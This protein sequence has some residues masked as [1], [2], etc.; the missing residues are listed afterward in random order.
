[1]PPVVKT[2]EQLAELLP[3]ATEQLREAVSAFDKL[4]AAIEARGYRVIWHM[5][6]GD[7]SLH[8][9]NITES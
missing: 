9:I 7:Y 1:M 2:I 6:S 4:K 3:I 5:H 8:K